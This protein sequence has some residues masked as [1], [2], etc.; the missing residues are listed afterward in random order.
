[1][2]GMSAQANAALYPRP[3]IRLI[4]H[5]IANAA[6][7]KEPRPR[8]QYRK[9]PSSAKITI[10]FADVTI[11]NIIETVELVGPPV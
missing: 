11:H 1:M 10:R 2:L 3:Q 5:V 7:S 8:S 9:A 4:I 6:T